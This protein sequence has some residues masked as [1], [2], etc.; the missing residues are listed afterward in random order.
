MPKRSNHE[1][2][3]VTYAGRRAKYVVRVT[4]PDGKRKAFYL[5]TRTEADEKLTEI[6]RLLKQ[7]TALPDG[8]MLTRTYLTQWIID[9]ETEKDV[10]PTTLTRYSEYVHYH[11]IPAIGDIPLNELRPRHVRAV[12]TAV[13]KKGLSMQTVLTTR[14]VLQNALND[15]LEDEYVT[16]NVAAMTRGRKARQNGKKKILLVK[17]I[18][19]TPELGK[20]YLNAIKDDRYEMLYELAIFLGIRLSEILGL[21]WGDIDL[22]KN[23]GRL[24]ISRGLHRSQSRWWFMEPKSVRSE[25]T[26]YLTPPLVEA[27]SN[28]RLAQIAEKQRFDAAVGEDTKSLWEGVG[29]IVAWPDPRTVDMGAG[30]LVFT[31]LSGGPLSEA[32]VRQRWI[33]AITAADLPVIRFHDIRHV[34]PSLLA[35]LNESPATVKGLMGHEDISTT[36]N[37]YTESSGTEQKKALDKLYAALTS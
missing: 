25:R 6:R 2:S 34:F 17:K 26:T 5:K 11:I 37:I 24:N 30:E 23:N 13:K 4:Q 12:Q 20:G 28:H 36:M 19:I 27:L 21:R 22:D 7:G 8:K 10:R 3:I 14:S 35:I 1:G 16:S 15:A 31:N 32:T 33:K 29:D 9:K 18:D